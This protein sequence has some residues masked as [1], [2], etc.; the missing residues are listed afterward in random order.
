MSRPELFRE[1]L[2]LLLFAGA[3]GLFAGEK[4]KEEEKGNEEENWKKEAGLVEKV[5]LGKVEIEAVTRGLDYLKSRQNEDGSWENKIGYKLNYNYWETGRGPHVGV[6]ALAALAFYSAGCGPGHKE[7]GPVVTKARDFILG[8]GEHNGY[9]IKN[10]T[11]MFGHAYAGLFLAELY[12]VTGDLKVKKKL[13]AAVQFTEAAQSKE[14]GWCYAPFEMI[15]DITVTVPQLQFLTVA[16]SFGLKVSETTLE[17]AGNYIRKLR[18]GPH[19]WGP[20][21]GYKY[22]NQPRSRVTFATTACGLSM[23][24]LEVEK[25]DPTSDQGLNFLVQHRPHRGR[26]GRQDYHYFFGHFYAVQVFAKLGGR[27]W[28]DWWKIVSRETVKG[29]RPDGRWYDEVGPNYATAMAVLILTAPM[30][31]LTIFRPEED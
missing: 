25:L 9:I 3:P 29:Q 2:C 26:P 4:E 16:R 24:R 7:Y 17:E 22:E 21:G 10:S 18:V 6:T 13:E 15:S 28:A 1:F 11:R 31:N 27:R 19:D 30:R 5:Q 23:E 20:A 14:G 12:G 8:C